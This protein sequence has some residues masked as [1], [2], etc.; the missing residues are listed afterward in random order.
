[1]TMVRGQKH[2]QGFTIVELLIVVVVIAI[3][4]A[5]TIVAYTGIQNRAKSSAAAATAGQFGKKLAIYAQ[6][7][8][9]Q[10]P[11]DTTALQT[12]LNVTLGANDRYIVDN[13]LNPAQCYLKLQ[14]N[15]VDQW[16]SLATTSLYKNSKW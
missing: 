3:L 10:Y 8:S 16:K 1:M 9:G 15:M 5:I 11:A 2:T 7:N 4:A 13:S 14:Y 6:T 12:F